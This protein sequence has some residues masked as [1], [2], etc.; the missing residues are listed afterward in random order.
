LQEK[1]FFL[2]AVL[3]NL[4]K[5]NSLPAELQTVSNHTTV[6]TMN[7]TQN[8]INPLTSQLKTLSINNPSYFNE[9]EVVDTSV[10]S[11]KQTPTINNV[12]SF[13]PRQ[14][15]SLFTS[16]IGK[17]SVNSTNGYYSS[18]LLNEAIRNDPLKTNEHLI[19]QKRDTPSSIVSNEET[20][21][22]NTTLEQRTSSM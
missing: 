5:I 22:S 13:P 10:Q 15:P 1:I 20:I 2:L 4:E 3:T 18:S 6:P 7:S 12:A 9:Y 21:R 8:R 19:S 11:L 16:T 14:T 17:S